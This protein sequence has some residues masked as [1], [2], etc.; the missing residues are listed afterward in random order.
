MNMKLQKHFSRKVGDKEY[1]KYVA[2]FPLEVIEKSG[3]REGDELEAETKEGKIIIRIKDV[4]K[5]IS[6]KNHWS[7]LALICV[8]LAI[9][10]WHEHLKIK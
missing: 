2:V 8:S 4:E 7:P 5:Q 3:F 1:S 9:D 6:V 10:Q